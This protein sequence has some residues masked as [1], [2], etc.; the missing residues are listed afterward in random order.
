VE[1]RIRVFEK[2]VLK[3]VPQPFGELPTWVQTRRK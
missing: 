2:R 3:K 1:Q